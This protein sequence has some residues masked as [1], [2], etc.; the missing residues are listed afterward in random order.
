MNNSKLSTKV[1]L[2]GGFL[3]VAFIGAVIGLTGIVNINKISNAAD[4]IL[5]EQVPL[6]DAS[7]EAIIAM[8]TGRDLMGEFLLNED[9]QAF[10]EISSEYKK[11]HNNLKEHITYLPEKFPEK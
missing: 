8:I 7:M 9:P 1:K 2:I 11:S 4:H 3:I 6:A 5:N 10:K